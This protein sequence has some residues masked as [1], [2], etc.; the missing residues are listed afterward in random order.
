MRP[1]A[2]Y[3]VQSWNGTG[4]VDVADQQRSPERPQGRR[5]NTVDFPEIST[6]RIRVVLHHRRGATSGL[7][8]IEAWGPADAAVPPPRSPSANLASTPPVKASR[9]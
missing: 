1:P 6:T 3:E 5:A 4:W 7:T 8:E 2:S 9:R